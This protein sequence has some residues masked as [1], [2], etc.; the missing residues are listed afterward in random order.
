MIQRRGAVCLRNVVVRGLLLVAMVLVA[1]CSGFRTVSRES[2]EPGQQVVLT[3]EL[4]ELYKDMASGVGRLRSLDGYADLYLSSPERKVKAYCTVQLQKSG[5]ARL[6]VSA[7]ILGW[8]VADMLIRPDSLFVNDMLNNRLLLGRNSGE[9]LGKIMGVGNGF[10]G[11][12]ETLFGI[13]DIPEPLSAIES[14]SQAEGRVSYRVRSGNGTRE[15]MVNS[16]SRDLAAI[17]GFDASGRKIVEFRFADYQSIPS[18]DG[19]LRMPMEID[20]M[21]YRENE[22]ESTR[23]LKVVYDER[24]INPPNLN[25]RYKRPKKAKTV[26][27][28]DIRRVPWM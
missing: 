4:E 28:E 11:L 27:L 22:T 9:N 16:I 2:F 8:P 3:A 19:E 13:A 20:M 14:V 26:N 5:N 1:G 23:S 18:A 17:T 10:S 6:I 15:L 25:I 7:G 12:T 24:V 21:L